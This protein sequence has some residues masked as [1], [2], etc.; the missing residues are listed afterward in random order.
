MGTSIDSLIAYV[1]AR[2]E[3]LGIGQNELARA[4]G[5]RHGTLANLLGGRVTRAPTLAT[6]EKLAKGLAV[7]VETLVRITRGELVEQLAEA[8]TRAG[9][10]L[11]GRELLERPAGGRYP[12]TDEEWRVIRAAERVGLK[13]HLEAHPRLLDV[14]P[15]ERLWIFRQLESL[16]HMI[17]LTERG[18][19]S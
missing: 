14:P 17:E 16:L 10:P 3:Q 15:G 18:S 8:R 7:D 9:A 12:L 2:R 13:W 11:P 5:L 6:L 4:C 19:S 1:K